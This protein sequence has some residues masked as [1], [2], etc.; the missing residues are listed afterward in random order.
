MW[1]QDSITNVL[2]VRLFCDRK[3]IF[4]IIGFGIFDNLRFNFLVLLFQKSFFVISEK[5]ILCSC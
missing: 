2:P 4:T 3:S 1:R 5:K